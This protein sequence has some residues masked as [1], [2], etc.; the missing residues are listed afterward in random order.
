MVPD[1]CGLLLAAGMN[2]ATV[3]DL[4]DHSPESLGRLVQVVRIGAS[5]RSREVEITE[6]IDS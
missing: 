5:V 3:S 4:V 1:P 6:M 2:R